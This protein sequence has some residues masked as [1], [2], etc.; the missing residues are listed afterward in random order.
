M[1]AD[2][3]RLLEFLRDRDAPCPVCGYNLRNL[4]AATCPECQH[5]LELTVGA[6]GVR[7][8]LFI[9]TLAPFLF[10]GMAALALGLLLF[11]AELAGGDPPPLLHLLT[12]VGLGSGAVAVAL[13][14]H[15]YRFLGF[16]PATQRRWA[17]VAWTAHLLPY[18][19]VLT[20]MLATM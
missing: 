19:G 11:V 7:I 5:A 10:S 9:A 6:T 13:I 1:S 8:G 12:L 18:L 3:D 20:L 14:I 2:T 17:L 16:T 4:T 15:R